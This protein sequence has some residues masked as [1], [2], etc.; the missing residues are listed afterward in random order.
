MQQQLA[1]ELT[2]QR[3]HPE[4]RTSQLME[5]SSLDHKYH[6]AIGAGRYLTA[7][8]IAMR[9]AAILGDHVRDSREEKPVNT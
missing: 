1:L 6:Q 2:A 5:L 8:S 3:I 7:A 9:C 4:L